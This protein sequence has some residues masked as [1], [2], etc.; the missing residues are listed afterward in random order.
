MNNTAKEKITSWTPAGTPVIGIAGSDHPEQ[1]TFMDFS[2]Q[3]KEISSAVQWEI[4]ESPAALPGF[5]LKSNILYSA[6]PLERELAPF[7]KGLDSLEVPEI[8]AG[9]KEALSQIDADC[10]LTL[11]IALQCPHCPA[12]VETLIPLAAACDKIHLHIIDGSVFP[13][14]AQADKVMSAPCL[15]LDDD[16]RWTGAVSAEEVLDMII[17]RG[18][19]DLD[20]PALKTILEEGRA[21]WLTEQMVSKDRLFKGFAGLLL[22]DTWS[23]RLGAMV[24]VEA[25]AGEAPDLCA[26]LEKILTDAFP[27]QPVPVQGDILYA[28]GEMGTPATRDWIT[29]Q[30]A[31]LNHE[32]LKD[33]ADDAMAS[34]DD[35]FPPSA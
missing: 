19:M 6:L 15:I 3:W 26:A 28:L 5:I 7:L 4:K 25:L 17:H 13:E 24:V 21:E 1:R 27:T 9:I 2:K 10:R 8:P 16:I 35:R 18:S 32:D 31:L 33:A 22:H 11:Y 14:K 30:L 29:A 23:V 12:M 34:I 20:T